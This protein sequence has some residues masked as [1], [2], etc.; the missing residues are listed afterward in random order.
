MTGYGDSTLTVVVVHGAWA[1]G[2]SWNKVTQPLQ[3]QGLHVIAA[4]IPL[5]SLSDDIRALDRVLE[6]TSGP[7]VIGAHAYAGAV[8][9]ATT[10]VRV[11]GLVFIAALTPDEGETVADVFYRG[12]PHAQ[13]PKLEPDLHG[14]IWM[15]EPSFNSAF[16]QD[17]GPKQAAL[18]AATQRPI[19]VACIQEKSPPPLWKR[20]P[21]WYLVA[22]QDRMINPDT[23][24]FMATRMAARTRIEDVDHTPILTNPNIVIEVFAAAIDG[25]AKSSSM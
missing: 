22:T 6:R 3:S 1:D 2:S 14:L 11:Q 19:S 8:I 24:R 20:K 21:A 10:N 25:T 4:P 5:T 15:P 17:A 23:Q 7:V 12:A 18:L 9:S 16:A 13:A